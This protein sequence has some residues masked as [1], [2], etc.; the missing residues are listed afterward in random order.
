MWE[1]GVDPLPDT[2]G[3]HLQSTEPGAGPEQTQ[4]SN[5][6]NWFCPFP[7]EGISQRLQNWDCTKRKAKPKISEGKF[8]FLL[9]ALG[10]K[11]GGSEG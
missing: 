9:S 10:A 7:L 6:Q 5:H 4:K 8:S 11:W 3:N 2:A 1:A